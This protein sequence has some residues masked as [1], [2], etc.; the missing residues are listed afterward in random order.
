MKELKEFFTVTRESQ[1]DNDETTFF[2]VTIGEHEYP[3]DSFKEARRFAGARGVSTIFEVQ[4]HPRM[5]VAE[6]MPLG[7]FNLVRL[8]NQGKPA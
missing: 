8:Y 4:R 2:T 5:I 6:Y 7:R 1:T 3:F